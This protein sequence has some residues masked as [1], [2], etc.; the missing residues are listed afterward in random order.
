MTFHVPERFRLTS[1]Q[2]A[3]TR[4]DGNNGRFVVILMFRQSVLVEASDASGWEH[5]AISRT[6]RV[7]SYGELRQ[8]KDMFWSPEDCVLQF[9]PP[10][11]AFIYDDRTQLHLWRPAGA[12]LPVPG[13]HLFEFNN[14][15]ESA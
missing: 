2:H 6:D 7:V 4:A 13:A 5:V 14:S 9:F 8:I 12:D 11:G 10:Q 1:G 3:T 15:R